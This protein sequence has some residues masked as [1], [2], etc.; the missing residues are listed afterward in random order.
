MRRSA[1]IFALLSILFLSGIFACAPAEKET[2][3]PD[4]SAPPEAPASPEAQGATIKL[5]T[6][7]S[8]DNSG[9]L[10]YLLPIFKEET[11]IQVDVIAVG[12]GAALELGRKGDVDVVL[13]HAPEAEEEFIAQ[14]YG[15]A[16]HYICQNEFVIVGSESDP[17]GIRG[18]TTAADAFALI[19]DSN[20]KFISRG[21][22]SGT[23][24]MEKSIWASMNVTPEGEWY[25]EAGQG[26]GA[27]LTMANE[28]QVYTLTDTGTFYSME[29]NLDLVILLSGDPALLNIYSIIPL[30]PGVHPDLKHDEAMRLVNWITSQE[31]VDLINGFEVNG[32]VL[33]AV[34][35]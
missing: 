15:V 9:L 30:N 29:D 24:K 20:S 35:K 14:G 8:V 10:A 3:T 1:W 21:D 5:A 11:G 13:V 18:A 32:H 7:T 22:D 26:M 34:A 12:T 6:T 23:H 31:A 27:V 19:R 17:A 25:I 33:F 4:G 28:M 2:E 16:H